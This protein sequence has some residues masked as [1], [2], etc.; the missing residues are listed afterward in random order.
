MKSKFL[1]LA[2]ILALVMAGTTFAASEILPNGSFESTTGNT[3]DGW[4]N[5]Q[6][7]PTLM[8]DGGY[9]GSNYMSLA[10][11][12]GSFCLYFYDG[13]DIQSYDPGSDYIIS[14]WVK[15]PSG[16]AATNALFKLEFD[17][18]LLLSNLQKS[19]FNVL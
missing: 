8:T 19:I 6:G 4:A 1:F 7:T 9:D 17:G 3:P 10:S 2:M 14:A 13:I 5:W 12:A 11:D 15:L 16:G 18:L